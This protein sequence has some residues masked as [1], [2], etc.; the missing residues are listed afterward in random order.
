VPRFIHNVSDLIGRV[1]F[2]ACHTAERIWFCSFLSPA[3]QVL[4]QIP[5]LGV[6][7]RVMAAEPQNRA[8]DQIPQF[9][10]GNSHFR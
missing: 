6:L 3:A 9:V 10:V 5:R 2:L 4:D 8:I 7:P 1:L